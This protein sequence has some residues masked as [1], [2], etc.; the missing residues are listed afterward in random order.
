MSKHYDQ[1]CPMAHALSLV[2]ERWSL[3]IVRELLR[4]P[5]RYTDLAGGLPGIGTNILASRLKDLE[6]GGIVEKRKL[7]PPAASTVYELTEYGAGLQEALYALARW[8]ARSLGPPT[9]KDDL[10][11]DW[12]LNALP[13]VFNAD[14]ARG[15]TETYVLKI[16]ED[17]FTARIVD[18]VLEPSCGAAAD[19]D[20]VGRDRPG[21]VLP[22]LRRRARAEGRGQ[23][24][25]RADRGR[26]GPARALLPGADLRAASASGGRLAALRVG[27]ACVNTQLPSSARTLRLANVTSE[28]LRE[29]IASNLDALETILRWN[30][31]HGVAVFRLTSN[32]IPFGSHAAN[33]LAWWDEFAPRLAE[34]GRLMLAGGMSI[35][36]HP[37][38]YTV[39]ASARPEVVD[40]AVAELDYHDRLLSA[41]GTC[42]RDRRPDP[43]AVRGFERLTPG[44][45]ARLVLENDERWPLD[46]SRARGAA[47]V[48]VV[49][50]VFHARARAVVPGAS[51][52]PRPPWGR[53]AVAV[54]DGRPGG[55]LLDPGTQAPG[56]R[57]ALDVE[58]FGD[59]PPISA[60]SR[61]TASL[62]VKDKGRS[63]CARR[64]CSATGLPTRAAARGRV[65]LRSSSSAQAVVLATSPRFE[66][67]SISSGS[68]SSTCVAI[69]QLCPY[70]SVTRANRSPQNMSSGSCID[71]APASSACLYDRVHVLDVEE[72]PDGRAADRLRRLGAAWSNGSESMISESPIASSACATLPSGP[73]ACGRA[74]S[75]R[76]PSCRTRSHPTRRRRRGTG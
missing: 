56:A 18:G 42:T 41:F 43:R 11:E 68:T 76:T 59:S 67:R 53:D 21:D 40:A 69:C 73:S 19:A 38:Q 14:E 52:R 65:A 72:D 39:L 9:K 44:A 29:L 71:V 58:A 26:P 50:D 45:A 28:R 74:P 75:R 25:P 48:P 51:R 35:S 5:K 23:E 16:G 15:L 12:G 22:A 36:T 30:E 62:E 46:R 64:S 24:R 31:A 6:E 61:S 32:L 33:E 47:G 63:C 7:P 2:G 3:L 57:R 27:Y 37:G 54:A 1:Y 55:S 17:V 10:Y 4:G 8:G 34:L 13:A 49:F 60:T 20:L 70:G 66:R